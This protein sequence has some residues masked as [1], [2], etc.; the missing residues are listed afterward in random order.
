LTRPI[1][2]LR[3]F[4]IAAAPCF[5]IASRPRFR[6]PNCLQ[7]LRSRQF[8]GSR[9]M[10]M[11]ADTLEKCMK[12]ASQYWIPTGFPFD[13][14]SFYSSWGLVSN[15]NIG[16]ENGQDYVVFDYDTNTGETA[17]TD[18]VLAIRQGRRRLLRQACHAHPVCNWRELVTGYSRSSLNEESVPTRRTV[19][20]M[21][22]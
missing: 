10:Y 6:R 12:A 4:G 7:H 5:R 21:T 8:G 18:T 15:V 22:Y 20:S 19:L 1:V 17:H 2:D 13:E 16:S 3:V 14:A 9:R 11:L